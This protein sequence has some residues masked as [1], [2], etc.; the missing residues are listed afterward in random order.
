MNAALTLVL[1]LILVALQSSGVVPF[2]WWEV[3]ADL[4]LCLVVRIAMTRGLAGGGALALAI[5]VLADAATGG[6]LGMHVVVFTAVFLAGYGVRNRLFLDSV[7]TIAALALFASLGATALTWLLVAVFVA[8]YQPY[9][10]FL[11]VAVPRALLTVVFMFP[12]RAVSESIDRRTLR[13][14]VRLSAT[15]GA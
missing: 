1:A 15:I 9:A 12:V 8:D 5:G 3:S 11:W 2:A 4:S 6:P 10:H 14:A 7:P 13:R